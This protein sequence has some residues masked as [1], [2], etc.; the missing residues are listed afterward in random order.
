MCRVLNDFGGI[1]LRHDC[2][3]TDLEFNNNSVIL[4]DEPATVRPV[5]QRIVHETKTVDLEVN[6]LKANFFTDSQDLLRFIRV[7][8]GSLEHVLQFKCLRITF[9]AIGQARD[10]S[11][12]RVNCAR[13]S[14]LLLRKA[15][16]PHNKTDL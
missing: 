9:Q 4:G 2:W 1:Q 11:K 15:L 7:N 6:T 12:F 10:K 3:L 16:L 13:K 14:F 5:L 8:G